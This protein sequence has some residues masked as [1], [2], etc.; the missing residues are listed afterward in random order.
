M[1]LSLGLG[2]ALTRNK[3]GWSPR[4]LGASLLG[5][6]D[7]ENAASV[8]QSA[9]AVS[10]WSDLVSGNAL[11]QGLAAQKPVWAASSLN[12][13]PGVTF[14]GADDNLSSSV[15]WL[16]TGSTGCEI[17]S[18]ASQSLAAATTGVR[19]IFAYGGTTNN[20]SRFLSRTTTGTVNAAAVSVGTGAAS[21]STGTESTG[22]D[23]SGVHAVRGISSPTQI[24]AA[25]DG[26]SGFPGSA[27]PATA[28]SGVTKLGVSTNG[29]GF[30]AGVLN[31][32]IITSL[33]TSDQ[34]AQLLKYLKKRGGLS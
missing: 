16:P 29:S 10:S 8:A 9:G 21:S 28:S 32:V 12:N 30:F 11:T 15:V 5:W 6:F 20:D 25:I 13:R 7:A 19:R 26:S 31:T 22:I 14:D 17:W 2:L 24:T 23:F 3:G 33:L 27:V 18:L 1:S 4:S 34:A